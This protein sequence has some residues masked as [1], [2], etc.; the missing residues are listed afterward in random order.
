[1]AFLYHGLNMSLMDMI[2]VVRGIQLED[3]IGNPHPTDLVTFPS[4][5]TQVDPNVNKA[6]NK[7]K[8]QVT[9]PKGALEEKLTPEWWQGEFNE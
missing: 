2:N 6:I 5:Y 9:Q 3:E 7:D 1:M 8:L 4:K